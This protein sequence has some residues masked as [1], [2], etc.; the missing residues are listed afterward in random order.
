MLNRVPR[1]YM[2]LSVPLICHAPFLVVF[3]VT[4][5]TIP[6]LGVHSVQQAGLAPVD[7]RVHQRVLRVL[8]V[9]VRR[10]LTSVC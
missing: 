2:V 9:G 8:L 1:R 7:A 5:G 10:S 6:R 3:L 4:A